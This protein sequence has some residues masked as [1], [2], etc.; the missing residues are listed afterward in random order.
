MRSPNWPFFATYVGSHRLFRQFL[1]KVLKNTLNE[2]GSPVQLKKNAK[3]W[4]KNGLVTKTL[5]KKIS[6][7]DPSVPSFSDL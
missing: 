2:R 4:T 1:L 5:V 3:N 6:N 7:L